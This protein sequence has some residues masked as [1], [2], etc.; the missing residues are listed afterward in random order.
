MFLVGL[1]EQSSCEA[2]VPG[3]SIRL[4]LDQALIGKMFSSDCLETSTWISLLPY[5]VCTWLGRSMAGPRMPDEYP[6]HY[7]FVEFR[8][9]VINFFH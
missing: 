6:F 4:S 5:V 9:E 7:Q 8:S 2:C 3:R 1:F